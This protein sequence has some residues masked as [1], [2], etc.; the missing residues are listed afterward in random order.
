MNVPDKVKAGQPVRAATINGLIDGVREARYGR[1]LRQAQFNDDT[2]SL[3]PFWRDE[4]YLPVV[5]RYSPDNDDCDLKVVFTQGYVHDLNAGERLP[6]FRCEDERV[7]QVKDGDVFELLIYVGGGGEVNAVR[8]VAEGE[9]DYDLQSLSDN[10]EAIGGTPSAELTAAITAS[11]ED[12]LGGTQYRLRVAEFAKVVVR[13][14]VAAAPGDD[15]P[16]EAV[17]ELIQWGNT[18]YLRND[19]VWGGV[20][21]AGCV[22]WDPTIFDDHDYEAAPE[23]GPDYKVRLNPGTINGVINASWNDAVSVGDG[24]PAVDALHYIVATVT[25]TDK[26][27]TSIA[28]SVDA[29]I[30]DGD[31]L[32]P[33]LSE[34]FPASLKIILGTIIGAS[35]T[36]MVWN[37]NL[38]VS[39]VEVFREVIASPAE[40]TKPYNS[41]YGFSI[42]PTT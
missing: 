41:Y 2:L 42:N 10:I 33:V 1:Q 12:N 14:A 30:P 25:F 35:E 29:A 27:V 34:A 5:D 3:H 24:N 13:E 4:E 26:Q 8:F 19:V 16:V 23:G 11:A 18:D 21:G 36:C 15:P 17:A 32:S 9:L 40:N 39:A 7:K 38:T 31:D 22:P 37:T 20:G 28:Y 6:V